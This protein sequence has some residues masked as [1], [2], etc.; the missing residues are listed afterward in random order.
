MQ[1][2]H[3]A[4][5]R[6]VEVVDEDLR[7]IHYAAGL[8]D[9]MLLARRTIEANGGDWMQIDAMIRCI[10]SAKVEQVYDFYIGPSVVLADKLLQFQRMANK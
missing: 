3:Y 2:V 7:D 1:K 5:P 8:T 10:Q 9:G 4:H 6:G